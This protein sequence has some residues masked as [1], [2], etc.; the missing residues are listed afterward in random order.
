MS[1]DPLKLTAQDVLDEL[2]E[3]HEL[4]FKLEAHQVVTEGDAQYII[5]FHDSR[6]HS[7]TVNW[8][9]DAAE[10]SFKEIVRAAVLDRVSRLSGPLKK[11]ER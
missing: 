9:P 8:N 3:E 10:Q 5:R 2:M 11:R 4:P 1:T 7:I 6:L